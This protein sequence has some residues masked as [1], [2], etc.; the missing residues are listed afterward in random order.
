MKL[1][2]KPLKQKDAGRGLAAIDREVMEELDV[3]HGDYVAVK[4]NSRIVCRVWPGYP[5]DKGQ[6]IIR[7]DGRLRRQANVGIDEMV[8]VERTDIEPAKLITVQ[9]PE[10]VQLKGNIEPVLRDQLSGRA[11]SPDQRLPIRYGQ[12]SQNIVLDIVDT[13]PTG[14]VVVTDA[15]AVEVAEQP[16]ETADEPEGD[17]EDGQDAESDDGDGRAAAGVLD[18]LGASELVGRPAVGALLVVG[19]F[20]LVLGSAFYL[21]RVTTTPFGIWVRNVG[22]VVLVCF[23]ALEFWHRFAR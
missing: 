16:V 19:T 20:V 6:R 8:A 17:E 14:P 1:T 10:N 21:D 9:F 12:G 23:G 15:T 7:I 11:I 5:E 13:E 3:E 18:R 4:G 2:V 22:T